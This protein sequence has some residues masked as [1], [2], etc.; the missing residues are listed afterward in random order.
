M[1]KL[2]SFAV[3]AS[4]A[5]MPAMAMNNEPEGTPK[6]KKTVDFVSDENL[7][8]GF[9]TESLNNAIENT[10][11]SD[12]DQDKPKLGPTLTQFA[13]AP[14]FGGFFIG[15][16]AYSDKD[17]DHN[18]TGFSQRVIRAYV[19]GTILKDFAYRI[20]VQTNNQAFH[21]KDFFVE[22]RKYKEFYVKVGQFKRAFGFENPMNPWDVGYGDYSQM[23]KKLT[24]HNDFIGAESGS[25]GGRDQG[26]QIQGDLFPAKDG[27]RFVHYQLMLSNGQ[28]INTAD[29][30]SHKDVTGTLQIQPI[31]GVTLGVFGWTGDFT[32]NGVT[33]NRNRYIIGAKVEQNGWVLRT[34]YG[35]ST[36]HKIADYNAE[37]KTWKGTGRADAMYATLGVP[38]AP[39]LKIFFTY[40]NYRDNGQW[41]TAKTIYSITPNIRL[42]KNLMFQLQYNYNHDR[43][44]ANRNYNEIWAE[45]YVRF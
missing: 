27:H 34:E 35:H 5:T 17:G 44:L 25:N 39:W 36:G 14:K 6:E 11:E 22:W 21:M 33:V 12:N 20:Q 9:V 32:S 31:K 2:F 3:V 26:I 30:N 15:K 29:A 28:G 13:S 19:D 38:V 4:L 24:G 10:W 42:H 7:E 16:Y 1:N 37:T 43:N 23:T 40:D 45:T 41:N 18:G 8:A